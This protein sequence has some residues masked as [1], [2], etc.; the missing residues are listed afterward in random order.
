MRVVRVPSWDLNAAGALPFYIPGRVDTCEF[1]GHANKITHFG[2]IK[3]ACTWASPCMLAD[4]SWTRGHYDTMQRQLYNTMQ[5]KRAGLNSLKHG[6]CQITKKLECARHRFSPLLVYT[7]HQ[8]KH[9]R[10]AHNDIE[11]E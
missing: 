3:I 2:L 6:T 11:A 10:T 1:V 9:K 5:S 8:D 7:E 4:V